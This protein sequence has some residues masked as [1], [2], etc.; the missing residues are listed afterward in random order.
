MSQEYHT[1][2]LPNE[3]EEQFALIERRD[4]IAGWFYGLMTVAAFLLLI[5]GSIFLLL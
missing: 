2:K 4:K 5:V 1:L 3:V